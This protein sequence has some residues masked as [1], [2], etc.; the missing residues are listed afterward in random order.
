MDWQE[1]AAHQRVQQRKMTAAP[2]RGVFRGGRARGA[3]RGFHQSTS[4]RKHIPRVPAPHRP[5]PPPLQ[6]EQADQ[7]ME[8]FNAWLT[9]DEEMEIEPA[10]R[11]VAASD[12]PL[13]EQSMAAGPSK[14]PARPPSP[15]RLPTAPAILLQP[16]EHM[17][18]FQ[19]PVPHS[20][21]AIP[22][23]PGFLPHPTHLPSAGDP[24]PPHQ[25]PLSYNRPRLARQV[26]PPLP[27]ILNNQPDE[28][29]D[30]IYFG[31]VH[32]NN[33]NEDHG[34]G[35]GALG[36][37]LDGAAGLQI[38][39][40]SNDDVPMGSPT[41]AGAELPPQTGYHV[42]HTFPPPPAPT[43]PS[44]L[45]IKCHE[46]WFVRLILI[47]IVFLHFHFHLPFAACDVLLY[48]IGT[49]L[50]AVDAI[51]KDEREK[52]P[53]T[54]KTVLRRLEFVDRFKKLP[55]CEGCHRL[56]YEDIPQTLDFTCPD[57]HTK[58]Y[59]RPT[60]SFLADMSDLL[61]RRRTPIPP[62]PRCV[63]PFRP[64]SSLLS[65][66]LAQNNMLEKMDSWRHKDR[67]NPA[68]L[69]D[70]MDGRIWKGLKDPN[71]KSFFGSETPPNETRIGLTLNFDS[72]ALHSEMAPTLC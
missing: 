44:V 54:L 10:P 38:E 18:A 24:P 40:E 37:L 23:S 4:P 49:I 3:T 35:G 21:P 59:E 43:P 58:I 17:F 55:R 28:R 42:T 15:R 72:Y 69:R 29:Q 5:S 8:E 45:Y 22:P 60:K 12:L 7:D 51:N 19:V 32:I 65:N 71:G 25:S 57:C 50:A 30:E 63:V 31:A 47:T 13:E 9:T 39:D 62:K 14:P 61:R 2:K 33:N 26:S 11:V 66:F 53:R 36:A 67:S 64:I 68:L 46:K 20:D 1:R 52:M 48:V 6:Q 16:Q 34:I 70:I 56:F 27:E 41:A